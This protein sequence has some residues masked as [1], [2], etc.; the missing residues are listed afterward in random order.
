MGSHPYPVK[1]STGTAIPPVVGAMKK[2]KPLT[3]ICNFVAEVRVEVTN[4]AYAEDAAREKL[5]KDPE[6]WK[7]ESLYSSRRRQ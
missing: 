4:S 7:L 6:L 3:V 2:E 5:A 1:A